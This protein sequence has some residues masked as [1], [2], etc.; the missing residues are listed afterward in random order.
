[1]VNDPRKVIAQGLQPVRE[2]IARR[3]ALFGSEQRY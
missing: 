1:D 3:M 2:M